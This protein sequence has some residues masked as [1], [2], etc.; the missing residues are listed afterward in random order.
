MSDPDVYPA[1]PDDVIEEE[2]QAPIPG[3]HR[4]FLDTFFSP[5]KL[6]EDLARNPVWAAALLVGGLLIALQTLLIPVEIWESMFRE[7][8]LQRGGDVPEGMQIGATVM[9]I[10]AVVGG[11]IFWF[12]FSF[13]MAGITTLVFA[14]VLGDEGRYRQYLAVL[15]HAWLIP[16]LVGLAMVPLRISESNPQLT[17]N[18]GSF[19]FFLPDGY[20]FKVLTMLDLSQLWAWLVI[21][22]GVH[23][24]DPR[25]SFKSAV[26]IL[27]GFALA[28]AMIFAPFVPSM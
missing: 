11:V 10:S 26:I 7:A 15:G 20:V 6:A 1:E 22:Q 23:A 27:F 2:V 4:R 16:A 19:F 28:M 24:I 13:L 14:F 3:L 17:L 25:R 18:L 9:R 8:A 21:A 12:V 5:G